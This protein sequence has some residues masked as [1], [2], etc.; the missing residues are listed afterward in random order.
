MGRVRAP[1]LIRQG[2][3]APSVR[4]VPSSRHGRTE[5]APGQKRHYRLLRCLGAG[6]RAILRYGVARWKKRSKVSGQGCSHLQ[7][8][9]AVAWS[10]KEAG[11][12]RQDSCL[13]LSPEQKL[14]RMVKV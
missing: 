6:T 13:T 9:L 1:G 4:L 8:T 11:W 7:A 3:L 12:P 5:A 10:G 14:L 2:K